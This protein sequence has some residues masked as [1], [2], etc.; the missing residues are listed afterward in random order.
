[1]ELSLKTITNIVNFSQHL[2]NV[3]PLVEKGSI[4]CGG[5]IYPITPLPLELVRKCT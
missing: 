2:E 4:V 1:M 5:I 3:K